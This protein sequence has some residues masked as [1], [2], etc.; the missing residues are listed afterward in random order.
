[1]RKLFKSLLSFFTFVYLFIN[2]KAA[3]AAL[4]P[5]QFDNLCA[6]RAGRAGEIVNTIVTVLLILAII[7][8][9]IYLVF[10]GIKWITSGGDKAKIDSARS[11]LTAAVVGLVVAFLAFAIV[12]ILS[13]MFTGKTF[14][15]FSIPTL[16][17]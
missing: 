3:H 9:L 8:S 13:V 16:L 14:N 4:C 15:S 10:G 5:P 11:H 17:D 6:L 1:M 12:N 7:L 2:A